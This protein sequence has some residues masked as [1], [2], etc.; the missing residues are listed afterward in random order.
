MNTRTLGAL[1]RQTLTGLRA[2]LVLTVILGI[3]YP[4]AVWAVGRAAF[5]D[6]ATGQ[7]VEVAG[8]PVGSAI[9]GQQ[10][11]EP[12]LFHSRPSAG[13][14]DPLA[15]GPSNL[16]PSNPDLL[17]QI[18]RRR[19][20]VAESEGI[21]PADVP[22]DALTASGSGLDPYISPEYAELQVPRVARLNGLTVGRVE[23]LLEATTD[24]R[25]LGYLGEPK[26]NVLELNL[27]VQNAA[28]HG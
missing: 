22:A 11:N 10:F 26:V 21:A 3:A 6:N 24:G 13:S 12:N 14:Y 7:L 2:F 9:I 16:G 23:L 4:V 20:E 17:K 15:S 18:D 25:I 28:D 5:P 8:T 27:A 1:A 19:T